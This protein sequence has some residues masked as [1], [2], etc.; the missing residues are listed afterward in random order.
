MTCFFVSFFFSCFTFF[1]LFIF[2]IFAYAFYFPILVVF[3]S[4]FFL[5][6]PLFFFH[7]FLPPVVFSSSLSLSLPLSL[8]LSP[9]FFLQLKKDEMG[10][11]AADLEAQQQLQLMALQHALGAQMVRLHVA[12]VLVPITSAGINCRLVISWLIS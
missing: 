8:F 10:H 6:F 5:A 12:T 11:S 3:L 9:L 1:V 2:F 7:F 4:P